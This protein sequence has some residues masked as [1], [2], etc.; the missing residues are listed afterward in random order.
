MCASPK[1]ICICFIIKRNVEGVNKDFVEF[2]CIAVSEKHLSV[3]DAAWN[4][5]SDE[6]KVI[7]HSHL[8][9]PTGNDQSTAGLIN[10]KFN[11]A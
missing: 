11:W 6:P 9:D 10:Y 1:P 7:R 8:G 2:Q 5:I 4:I 3:D